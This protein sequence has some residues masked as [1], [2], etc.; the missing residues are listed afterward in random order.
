MNCRKVAINIL[1][2]IINEGAYSNIILS[3]ELNNS[4]LSDKDK[5]LVTEIVYGTLRRLKTIDKVIY[6]LQNK[7]SNVIITPFVTVIEG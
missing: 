3:N 1:E 6:F 5:A 2:R 4:D 7:H